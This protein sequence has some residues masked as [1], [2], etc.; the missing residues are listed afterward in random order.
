M[1]VIPAPG[2]Q[3]QEDLEFKS[4]LGYIIRPYFKIYTSTKTNTIIFLLV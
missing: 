1:P 4:S 3:K 2:R